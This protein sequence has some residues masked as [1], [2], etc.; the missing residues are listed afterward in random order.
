MACGQGE[1]WDAA[2]EKFG[3]FLAQKYLDE[4]GGQMGTLDEVQEYL[5][6][7]N[8]IPS[9]KKSTKLEDW[10]KL[11]DEARNKFDYR[12]VLYVRDEAT[13]RTYEKTFD[14]VQVDRVKENGEFYWRVIIMKPVDQDDST[15]EYFMPLEENSKPNPELTSQAY[16]VD[17][18]TRLLER[19]RDQLGLDFEVITRETA[20]KMQVNPNVKSFL[21]GD[22]VFIIGDSM[23]TAAAFHEY[24]HALVRSLAEHNSDLFNDLYNKLARTDE[25][26]KIIQGVKTHYTLEEDSNRFKA[27]VLVH[28]ITTQALLIEN[29]KVGSKSFTEWISDM[30]YA[31]KQFLRKMFGQK[32]D[33]AKLDVNTSIKDLAEM[34]VK[35]ENFKIDAELLTQEN[36][37]EYMIDTTAQVDDMMRVPADKTAELASKQYD[38][39]LRHIKAVK[40]NKNLVAMKEV[41]TDEFKQK[42]LDAMLTNIRKYADIL[43][44][45]FNEVEKNVEQ[46]KKRAEALVNSMF[47]LDTMMSKILVHMETLSENKD[48]KGN[49]LRATS[50]GQLVDYW[51]SYVDEVAADLKWAEVEANAPMMNLVSGIQKR[52]ENIQDKI[53][54]INKFGLR[55][56]LYSELIPMSERTEAL[57]KATIAKLKAKGTKQSIVDEQFK[58][59]YGM[60][61]AELTE[62]EKLHARHDSNTST[63]LNSSELKTYKAL[64]EK[65][66]RGVRMTPQKLNKTLAGELGDANFANSFFEGYMY[67]ADPVVGGFALYVKNNMTDVINKSYDKYNN[68]MKDLN[69]LMTAA[70]YNPHKVNDLAENICFVDVV[71]RVNPETGELERREVLT[72]L[73]A[74]QDYR[75]DYDKLVHDAD[76]AHKN[77]V[78]SGTKEDEAKHR[79]AVMALKKFKRD[80]MY[81][82]YTQEYYDKDDFFERDDVG[83]AAAMKR[84]HILEQIHDKQ[85]DIENSMDEEMLADEIDDLWAQYKQLHSRFD[86]NGKIKSAEDVAIAEKLQEYKELTRHFYEYVQRPGAF[87]TALLAYE[88]ELINKKLDPASAEYKKQRAAWIKKNTRTVIKQDYYTERQRLVDEIGDIMSKLPKRLSNEQRALYKELRKKERQGT[89]TG[90]ETLKINELRNKYQAQLDSSV[91]FEDLMGIAYTNRDDDGQPE[92][93]KMSKEAIAETK[94]LQEKIKLAQEE[95]IGMTG[96]TKIE[97]RRMDELMEIHLDP[98]TQLTY[99]EKKELNA[100]FSKK[101][102]SGLSHANKVRLFGLYAELR[103]L[104]RKDATEYYVQA[105][106][107]QLSKIDQDFLKLHLGTNA[108]DITT[109]DDILDMQVAYKLMSKNAEFKEW[110]LANHIMTER[111]DKNIPGMTKVWERLYVWNVIRPSDEKYYEK[112]EIY[113]ADHNLV[114]TIKAQPSTRYFS[115]FVKKEYHTEKIVGKTISNRG[116]EDFLPRLMD[117][118][119]PR[120]NPVDDK[121]IN[122][123]Y[124]SMQAAD[125]GTKEGKL[126][127]VLEKMKEHHLNNQAGLGATK[128]LYND[129]PRYEKQALELMQTTSAKKNLAA[130]AKGNFPMLTNFIKVIKNTLTRAKDDA[131]RGLNKDSE[132]DLVRADMFDSEMSNIHLGGLYDMDVNIVSTDLVQSINKHMLSAERYKKLVEMNPVAQALKSDLERTKIQEINPVTGAKKINKTN[133]L[134]RGTISYMTKKGRSIR[135]YA[136]NN[137]YDREWKNE[138]NTG[139]L[140]DN[141]LANTASQL[142]FKRAAF[143]FFALNIPSALKNMIG[144]KWQ[145]MIEASAG[146]YINVPSLVRGEPKAMAAMSQLS[147]N[148]Y[149]GKPQPL[150]VQMMDYFG[151]IQGRE[152]EKLGTSMSRTISSDAINLSWLYNFRK[153]T[154]MEATAHLFFGMMEFQKINMNG[155]EIS[156]GDAFEV[157]DGMLKLKESIDVRYDVRHTD[158]QLTEDDTYE[159]LMKKYNISKEEMPKVL[160]EEQFNAALLRVKFFQ[161][162]R[163]QELSMTKD[164]D[165]KIKINAKYDYEVAKEGLVKI[166]NTK[167]KEIKNRIQMTQNNL[168]GAYSRFDQPEA[169]RYLAYRFFSFLRKYF[170][171]MFVNRFGYSGSMLNP[172]GRMNPGLS[173]VPMGYY[174]TVL[175][176]LVRTFTVDK[177]YL[178]NMTNDEK[179][180]WLKTTV[181][182]GAIL[183]ITLA[184][185]PLMGY[186]PDDPDRYAKL[187]KLSGAMPFPGVADDPDR[188]FNLPGFMQLHMIN[189]AMQVR[190]ENESMMPWPGA[191]MSDYLAI[192]QLKSTAMG[193]TVDSYAK[194]FSLGLSEISG[195]PSAYYQ[196]DVGPYEWQRASGSKF[197]TTFMKMFGLAGTSIDPVVSIKNMESSRK[198][199][200]K[201]R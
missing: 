29:D 195:D 126:F 54:A 83:R 184:M 156:Y 78:L 175:R 115:R 127:K 71:G 131:E 97:A 98:D 162:A 6:Q 199:A 109:A 99:E 87:Q 58:E 166:D 96:L 1:N 46:D 57:Y 95:L 155:R 171:P 104:S 79:E 170:T 94:D 5:I 185:L 31:L 41:L 44:T 105:Y 141:K 106:N 168:Q 102:N 116:K 147:M 34:L 8:K 135:A 67:N 191:G 3:P 40:S 62:Y 158:H 24:S 167:F 15:L 190:A 113:D 160:T 23:S 48:N 77:Y 30:L 93:T 150:Y 180:A 60:T 151:A 183:A 82:E 146:K 188:E 10:N 121:Y 136:V 101:D 193:P 120:N 89:L 194:L 53:Q 43:Q 189:M 36:L 119:N 22:K 39:L 178:F 154:E 90:S 45:K 172:R 142:I 197:T 13:A 161:E 100:L 7:K 80:Y 92:G 35:G 52:I 165:A 81:Q 17:T 63:P 56:I 84:D 68:F 75:Y 157:R 11:R 149:S 182:T 20:E 76:V 14:R 19:L 85:K 50:Y 153:W 132:F 26:V 59:F 144:P 21:Q 38:I 91:L 140:S 86:L 12:K 74:H 145:G 133:L 108:I 148:I 129:V 123:R 130:T 111:Y 143:G 201:L 9:E 176:S 18:I 118:Q 88:Q 72:F 122:K 200:G 164:E 4:H 103:N 64:Q 169:Q 198:T 73:N 173:D 42:D 49:L 32:V 134:H 128:K 27:E 186:D 70:G 177:G 181:E 55:D 66:Y 117:P 65:S 61:E 137:F 110:F 179:K 33:V 196:R 69:P 138:T 114:E 2:L 37:T 51:K 28:A 139:W 125:P 163:R 47:R 107:N 16:G 124:F 187:R 112:T 159:G 25:G 174:I 192:L 152:E